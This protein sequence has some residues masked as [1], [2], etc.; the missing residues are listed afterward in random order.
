MNSE[1]ADFDTLSLEVLKGVAQGVEVVGTLGRGVG[2]EDGAAASC[3]V[4][5]CR[6]TYAFCCASEVVLDGA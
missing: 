3:E 5:G 1:A 2:S 6:A 4:E